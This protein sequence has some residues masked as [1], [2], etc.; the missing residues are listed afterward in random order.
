M[1]DS[2]TIHMEGI[3]E[4]CQSE[5]FTGIIPDISN[6]SPMCTELLS[7]HDK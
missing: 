2:F 6:V 1:V 3:G 4:N 5:N 7:F